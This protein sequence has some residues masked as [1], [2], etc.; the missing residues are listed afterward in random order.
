[1][2]PLLASLAGALLPDPERTQLLRRH[3]GDSA[4]VSFLL[5][6]AEFVAGLQWV[7]GSALDYL[8]PLAHRMA[9]SYLEQANQRSI[10]SDET[11]GFTLGGSVLWLAWLSRPQ[12]WF[13][14][15]IPAVGLVRTITFLSSHDAIGEPTV[16]AGVRLYQWFHR[17][18]AKTHE[19]AAFGDAAAPDE[20]HQDGDD[21]L[22][23]CARERAEWNDLVTIEIGER[24]YRRIG[25][26]VVGSP[27]RGGLRRHRYRL[28]EQPEHDV[29]RRLIRYEL[30]KTG[31]RW[32]APA[33]DRPDPPAPG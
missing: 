19:R 31:V 3:G 11:L 20:V 17:R 12:T 16:W 7:V 6:A 21:L 4:W 33:A 24:F 22:V 30:P 26:E 18:A 23:H 32:A 27:G 25:H 29:I 14:L 8:S 10:G 13:L 2:G 1:M 9:D 5:G 28:R 15:S